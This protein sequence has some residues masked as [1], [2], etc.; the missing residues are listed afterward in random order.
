M[1]QKSMGL[2]C[3][4]RSWCMKGTMEHEESD[5]HKKMIDHGEMKV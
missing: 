3:M 1:I 4:I 5:V 2:L